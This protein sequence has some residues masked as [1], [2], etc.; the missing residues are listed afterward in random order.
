MRFSFVARWKVILSIPQLI[1]AFIR[2]LQSQ[3]MVTFWA[4]MLFNIAVIHAERNTR[5]PASSA[6]DP[7]HA[8]HKLFG[9]GLPWWFWCNFIFANDA[10]HSWLGLLGTRHYSKLPIDLVQWCSI[11]INVGVSLLHNNSCVL[12]RGVVCHHVHWHWSHSAW[13]LVHH[14]WVIWLLHHTRL[15]SITHWLLHHVWVLPWLHHWLLGHHARLL[16]VLL[17]WVHFI[18]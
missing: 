1:I 10:P 18:L 13:V 15:L 16:L 8:K 12:N 7:Q 11:S 2:D 4:L 17:I 6:T 3:M 9:C 14:I 5:A